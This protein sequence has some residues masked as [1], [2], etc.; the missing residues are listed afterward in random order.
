MIIV[1]LCTECETCIWGFPKPG[2]F[3]ELHFHCTNNISNFTIFKVITNWIGPVLA[4]E[5]YLLNV[6]RVKSCRLLIQILQSV[7]HIFLKFRILWLY[8]F[9]GVR[10]LFS[11]FFQST[12]L[13]S[14]TCFSNR[15][16]KLF[17]ELVLLHSLIH[18]IMNYI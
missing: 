1:L 17:Y 7:R 8:M 9:Y 11:A 12:D 6:F 15:Q 18:P 4:I 10:I 2:Y 13:Y 3:L 16:H 5:H 14:S